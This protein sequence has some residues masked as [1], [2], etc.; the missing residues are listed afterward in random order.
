MSMTLTFT[1]GHFLSSSIATNVYFALWLLFYVCN[2]V[3]STCVLRCWVFVSEMVTFMFV[4]L[5]ILL[6]SSDASCVLRC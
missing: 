3:Y 6:V 1:H 2:P 5:C 4:T